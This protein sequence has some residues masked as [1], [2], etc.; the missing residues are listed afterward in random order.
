MI[1]HDILTLY[2]AK[3]I[4]YVLGLIFL[5]LFV[6][7]WRY[8]F[9]GTP[10]EAAVPAHR[11]APAN[12]PAEWFAVPPDRLFH[13]GHAWAQPSAAGLV[14]VGLDDFAAK[15]TGSALSFTLPDVN[16]Q[17][18][19]GEAG[20][21]MQ[22]EGRTVDMLSPI[23]G[24]VVE[25]NPALRANPETA[26]LDPYGRG[27]L[28]RV[29]PKRLR[30]NVT[31]LIAGSVARKWMEEV[32]DGLRARVAPGLGALAQDGGVPVAGMAKSIDPE[33]WDKLARVF[34]LTDG[35]DLNA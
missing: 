4:E 2:S 9:G 10:V 7:F 17:V 35:E 22:A 8:V 26:H 27:W 23:D 31:N 3:M 29:Q 30:A 1:P 32:A 21:R 15:L 28:F 13:R 19:Q 20:W 11:T 14:T 16:A 5:V 24:T 12:G 6:P 33:N 18:T 34:L 25:V